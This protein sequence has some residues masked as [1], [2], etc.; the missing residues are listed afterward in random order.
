MKTS[1]SLVHFAPAF[2]KAQAQIKTAV[3]DTVNPFYKSHFAGLNSVWEAAKD[4]LH[5]NGF[6]VSQPTTYRDG[7]M[8]LETIVLHNS[9]EFIA[10]E[11]LITTEKPGPQAVGAAITYAK[12]Y[13]LASIVGVMSGDIEDDGESATNHDSKPAAK[14]TVSN[15]VR[16]VFKPKEGNQDA[17]AQ[18]EVITFVPYDV[19]VKSGEGPKGPYTKY[20]VK[21]DG[22]FYSTFDETQGQ[23]LISAQNS[24]SVARIAFKK[25]GKYNNIQKVYLDSAPTPEPEQTEVPF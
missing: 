13:A 3:K 11:Y 19:K 20:D 22:V 24:G 5:L 12:R 10:G 23:L 18:A 14:P 17:P 16:E 4:A 15:N 8:L 21:N 2:V 25:A 6:T 1:D 9:G 7:V